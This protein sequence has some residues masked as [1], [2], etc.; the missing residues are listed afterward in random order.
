[1]A[2]EG[3]TGDGADR[4]SSIIGE[5]PLV[6]VGEGAGLDGSGGGVEV[7]GVEGIGIVVDG[8]DIEEVP[9]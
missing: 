7:G 1:M 6:G 9:D 8:G 3:S 4:V 5:V 2:S